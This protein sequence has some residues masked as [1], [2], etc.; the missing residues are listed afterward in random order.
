MGY[1][2]FKGC[3]L[4]FG[5]TPSFI[6]MS[7]FVK[8]LSR[9]SKFSIKGPSASSVSGTVYLD[10]LQFAP[11]ISKKP[12]RDQ[13]VPPIK[14]AS[15]KCF[16]C[17]DFN[18]ITET[19]ALAHSDQL[20]F[21]LQ[22]YR[23]SLKLPTMPPSAVS[24]SKMA[25]L[26]LVTKRLINWYAGE[27][28]A[29]FNIK[30]A[31]LSAPSLSQ[32]RWI[33]LSKRDRD[34]TVS[35][36]KQLGNIECARELFAKL[37]L[38]PVT[39]NGPP[40]FCKYCIHPQ[41]AVEA[42]FT[43][44]FYKILFPLSLE[45]F[46][47]SRS[48]EV[49]PLAE[50]YDCAR[51]PNDMDLDKVT[52]QN[53]ELRKVFLAAYGAGP[54]SS[55]TGGSKICRKQRDTCVQHL[56]NTVKAVNRKR[57]EKLMLLFDYIKDQGFAKGSGL[58]TLEH[59]MLTAHGFMHASFLM[60]KELAETGRLSDIIDTMKWYSDFGEVYQDEFEYKGTSADRMRT[61]MIFRLLT[62][63]SMPQNTNIQKKSKIRDAEAMKR[64]FDNVL[65]VNEGFSGV[66]KPDFTGF[67]HD[68]IYAGAYIP[69]ALHTSSLI[70]YLLDGTKDFSLAP[71]S[72]S[73]LK[74]ALQVLATLAAKYSV[75]PSVNGRYP[76]Y[77]SAELGKHLSAFA[78]TAVKAPS[79][80]PN[81]Y[82]GG[83]SL[84]KKETGE[85]LRLFDFPVTT[86][87]AKLNV[88]SG[89]IGS[90]VFLN[91]L[92]AAELLESIKLKSLNTAGIVPS[93]PPH[94]NWAKN[95]AALSIH[96]R[97]NWSVTVKG[98]NKH[99]FAY[100]G[101][102]HSH[103]NEYGMY[104]SYGAMLIAND[105]VSLTSKDV[106]NGWDWRKIPGTTAIG[107]S[108]EDLKR[109]TG[110]RYSNPKALAG[111]VTMQASR[112][113]SHAN[114]AFGMDFSQPTMKIPLNHP[115][116]GARFQFKKSVFFFDD[117][118]VSLGSDISSLS[119]Q[120]VHT[121]L[122]Q[123]IVKPVTAG[124]KNVPYSSS[125]ILRCNDAGMLVK[126]TWN[127]AKSVILVDVNGNRYYVAN[128]REM[129][130]V[131]TRR[132][133][134]NSMRSAGIVGESSGIYCTAWFDHGPKPQI[135]ETGG[136]S[137]RI[138]VGAES[139]S[140]QSNFKTKP[141]ITTSDYTVIASSNE[142]HAIKFS[143]RS[144]KIPRT[145]Y[146]YVNFKAGY[147]YTTGPLKSVDA[148]CL[149]MI[150]ETPSHLYI[151]VSYPQ[152]NLTKELP[153]SRNPNPAYCVEDWTTKMP[154]IAS[155][156][157]TSLSFCATNN[158]SHI[159]A[160]LQEKRAYAVD[161]ITVNG[162]LVSTK[163]FPY[164]ASIERLPEGPAVHF[165]SLKFGFTTE[166]KLTNRT[167]TSQNKHNSC[168]KV[169]TDRSV[170]IFS[171][172]YVFLFVLIR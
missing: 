72:K 140:S 10:F 154:T 60:R 122:F 62:V 110:W 61:T 51:V 50:R 45:H 169:K 38:N 109:V 133:K 2:E 95:Y 71:L 25:Q 93:K 19:D 118:I 99:V 130:L 64:W 7:C 116:Q 63:L 124:M 107:M 81:G 123:D 120:P 104:G 8:S 112:S 85:F 125:T 102:P 128:P 67:H 74:N 56:I 55:N 166:V 149:L 20:F 121:T 80:M 90:I 44:V 57:R 94:G 157:K 32:Q 87:P 115:L 4:N 156:I 150:E 153:L 35:C 161:S 168:G 127:P 3:P 170:R 167:D 75:P 39:K 100:E 34:P 49:C 132:V 139:E 165:L 14:S 18:S 88:C 69:S 117:V 136:Y 129:R 138:Q 11:T 58:G 101:Y 16:K 37:N 54:S 146:S 31:D 92:G 148:Q 143:D 111:G 96:R 164:Y 144:S 142:A 114:G 147:R 26:E 52:G 98:F 21:W 162:N 48:V 171:F 108:Y 137:Y 97:A 172:L 82:L 59:Q 135:L 42:S 53:N 155:G 43:D 70:S 17:I 66:I 36:N 105:E 78:Y 41:T 77:N 106:N 13:V 6:Y 40:L 68:M 15:G 126:R 151:S 103:E 89:K 27:K 46:I 79:I 33:H 9:I 30:P 83:V 65:S 160:E 76:K 134:Q 159:V 24:R 131:F 86:C 23:W 91:S 119:S 73:N 152:L 113:P 158:P 5:V 22:S 47:W 12:S 141:L 29:Y 145:V 163:D 1:A 28:V 84:H